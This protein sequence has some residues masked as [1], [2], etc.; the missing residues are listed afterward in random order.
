MTTI[1]LHLD[2]ETIERAQRIAASRAWTMEEL[3]AAALETI[4]PSSGTNDPIWGLFADK[5]E[6]LDKIAAGT[7]RDRKEYPLRASDGESTT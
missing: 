4:D 3:F 6:L 7:I 2:K 1:E 5:P